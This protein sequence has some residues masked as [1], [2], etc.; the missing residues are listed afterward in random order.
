MK[1]ESKKQKQT[2]I[3]NNEEK[4]II[5]KRIHPIYIIHV[6]PFIF[7]PSELNRPAMKGKVNGVMIILMVM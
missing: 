3:I 6:F 7:A 2:Q 4:K 1:S 5:I